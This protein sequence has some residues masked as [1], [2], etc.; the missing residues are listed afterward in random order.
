MTDL[1]RKMAKID[2]AYQRLEDSDLLI[3]LYDLRND[4]QYKKLDVSIS[5]LTSIPDLRTF[6]Q[7]D[8]L[9]VLNLWRNNFRDI[10]FSLI[11]LTVTELRL[12]GNK[13][14]RIGDLSQFIKLEYL[15][16]GFNQITH[17]DWRNLP[18]ALTRLYLDYNQLTTVGD[19]SQC[20]RLSKLYVHYNHI[21]YIEWRN[22]PPALTALHL[23]NNQLITVD[24]GHCTQLEGVNL[25]DNPTLHTIQSLPN[26]HFEFTIDSRARVLGRKC[27][28]ENTYHMLK[29]KC[30]RW[31][32]EQPPVEVLL[33]GL[34][35]VLDYYTEKSIRT[36]HTR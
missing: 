31:K 10:D 32:L 35:A 29:E 8:N 13:L 30:R 2:W 21:N 24:M 11:P 23:Y 3:K 7:F 20:I 34:E 6:R 15:D 25:Y 36:T 14:T 4:V 22:L 27:F 19:C 9:K 1:V 28:H 26:K 12:S 17:V 18:P 33:Q 5:K 16:V